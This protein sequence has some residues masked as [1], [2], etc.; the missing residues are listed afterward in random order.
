MYMGHSIPNQQKKIQTP[1]DFREIWHKHGPF[2][3]TF[4]HQIWLILLASL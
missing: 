3:E 4:L 1:L 2:Q